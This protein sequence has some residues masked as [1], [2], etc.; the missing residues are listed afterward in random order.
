M[1]LA[2]YGLDL[3]AWF[4]KSRTTLGLEGREQGQRRAIVTS[5]REL[6]LHTRNLLDSMDVCKEE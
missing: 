1:M 2:F 6:Y 4:F 3:V 5:S